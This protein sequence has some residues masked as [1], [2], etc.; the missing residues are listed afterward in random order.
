MTKEEQTAADLLAA[1][2]TLAAEES[3]KIDADALAA[4]EAARTA[5]PT[6]PKEKQDNRAAYEARK[7]REDADKL[8]KE[9]DGYKRRDED[10]RK[11]KLTEDQKLK[12]ERDELAAENSRL[13]AERLQQ[14]IA[15][16]F[17]LP[18]ALA[19]RLIGTDEDALRAD[20]EELSKLVALRRG[21]SVTDPARENGQKARI[22]TR[23]ELQADPK[24]AA[25]PEVKQAAIEG[26]VK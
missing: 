3:A 19:S 22:Y 16:E 11:S 12:E 9:L 6:D 20:A 14:K 2:D 23:A 1:A 17:K 8:R 25:S 26:R 24:L 4:E 13:K 21:G 15:A 18:D 10:A 7:A 5:D